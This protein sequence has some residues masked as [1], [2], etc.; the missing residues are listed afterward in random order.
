MAEETTR[1]ISI[2]RTHRGFTLRRTGAAAVLVTGTILLAGC[3]PW[4]AMNP[5][6]TATYDIPADTPLASEIRGISPDA[7]NLNVNEA[8][9]NPNYAA[10]RSGTKFCRA[11]VSAVTVRGQIP[12]DVIAA[13]LCEADPGVVSDSGGFNVG[14]MLNLSGSATQPVPAGTR[15]AKEVLIHSPAA[16]NLTFTESK[17]NPNYVS[18]NL[19]VKWKTLVCTASASG[20]SARGQTPSDI[21]TVPWCVLS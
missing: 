11:E 1:P 9:Q 6:N 14:S 4:A 8:K 18:Y 3:N 19:Q 5:A 17:D 12:G 2:P 13:P 21:I 16:T 20:V 10:W 7:T 15:L